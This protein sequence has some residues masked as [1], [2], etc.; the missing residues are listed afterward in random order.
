MRLGANGWVI[1]EEGV[2]DGPM[3]PLLT[4]NSEGEAHDLASQLR[5]RGLRVHVIAAGETTDELR[6]QPG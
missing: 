3:R 4:V 2:S 6:H 1:A 5:R